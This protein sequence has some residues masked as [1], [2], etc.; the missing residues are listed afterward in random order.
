VIYSTHPSEYIDFPVCVCRQTNLLSVHNTWLI[1]HWIR[2]TMTVSGSLL[3]LLITLFCWTSISSGTKSSTSKT[4]STTT[5]TERDAAGGVCGGVTDVERTVWETGRE[6]DVVVAGVVDT[7][8]SDKTHTNT[9]KI[10]QI[11]KDY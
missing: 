10:M 11:D 6:D 2:H 9:F 3:P 7:D 1:T 4:P 5:S 8:K